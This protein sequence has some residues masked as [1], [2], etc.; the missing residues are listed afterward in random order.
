MHYGY[1]IICKTAPLV[2]STS[3]PV[4][5]ILDTLSKYSHDNDLAVALNAIFAMGWY[6]QRP[7]RLNATPTSSLLL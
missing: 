3:N 4:V 5:L 2:M 7:S 1:P 6:E